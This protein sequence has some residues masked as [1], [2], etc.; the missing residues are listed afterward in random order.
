M[1]QAKW[2]ESRHCLESCLPGVPWAPH[3]PEWIPSCCKPCKPTPGPVKSWSLRVQGQGFS[4]ERWMAGS[5]SRGWGPGPHKEVRPVPCVHHLPLC[6]LLQWVLEGDRA[7]HQP[8]SREP[9]VTLRM[10]GWLAPLKGQLSGGMEQAHKY[11]VRGK[12]EASTSTSVLQTA[13]VS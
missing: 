6:S 11:P 4:M 2:P 9:G 12:D 8:P 13:A 10:C 1:A 3:L 7:L 5:P